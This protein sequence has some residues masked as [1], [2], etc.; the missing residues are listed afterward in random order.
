MYTIEIE[1]ILFNYANYWVGVWTGGVQQIFP[2]YR[3]EGRER[4]QEEDAVDRK[5]LYLESRTLHLL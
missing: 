4:P 3:E 5:L 1:L 2:Y